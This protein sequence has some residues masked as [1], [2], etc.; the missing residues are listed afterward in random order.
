MSE[1]YKQGVAAHEAGKSIHYNPYRHRGTSQQ[2]SDWESG[3][4]SV[5]ENK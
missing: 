5:G 4:K 1:E 2:Y 3:W